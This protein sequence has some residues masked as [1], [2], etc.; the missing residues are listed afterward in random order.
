MLSG[1]ALQP[2]EPLAHPRELRVMVPCL[3]I[4]PAPPRAD[5]YSPVWFIGRTEKLSSYPTR[6]LP[7]GGIHNQGT[8]TIDNSTFSAHGNADPD[9]GGAAILNE[10]TLTVK[11]SEFLGNQAGY[12]GGAIYNVGTL[13]VRHST[14]SG[15]AALFEFGGHIYNIGGTATVA[16]STFSGGF[17]GIGGGAIW[18]AG[19]SPS[20]TASSPVT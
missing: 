19:W 14:F 11:N 5:N 7:R 1:R 9:K 4:R 15:N 17:A 13:T 2:V 16:H 18:G 12:S 3:P 10:G 6:S 8:L 20:T